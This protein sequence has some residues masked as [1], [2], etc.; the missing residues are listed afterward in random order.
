[1]ACGHLGHTRDDLF[2]EPASLAEMLSPVS[3]EARAVA[4]AFTRTADQ[5][6]GSS[7][8]AQPSLGAQI[9]ASL[10][11]SLLGV[12]G[13]LKLAHAMN[14][15]AVSQHESGSS[16]SDG[17]PS[18]TSSEDL[19][20][21]GGNSGGGDSDQGDSSGGGDSGGGDSDQ[22]DSSGGGDSGGGDSDQGDSSGGGDSGG[23]DSREVNTD[24]LADL[25]MT[26]PPVAEE[27]SESGVQQAEPGKSVKATF[28]ADRKGEVIRDFDG[29]PVS[30]PRGIDP[31]HLKV[32]IR[33]K[34][35]ESDTGTVFE[36]SVG[37]HVTD[38]RLQTLAR[39]P[40]EQILPKDT[41]GMWEIAEELQKKLGLPGT[42]TRKAR[43]SKLPPTRGDPHPRYPRIYRSLSEMM[44]T[45]DKKR[46]YESR[47]AE[48]EQKIKDFL[49]NLSDT[50]H[51]ERLEK[52][53]EM[54][55]NYRK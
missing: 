6:G 33:H 49:S 37:S 22:G 10:A 5:S 45:L 19:G 14:A 35:K 31:L 36:T 8:A 26:L 46:G 30:D 34:A 18:D 2:S 23:G 29:K 15:L 44:A 42:Q 51:E 27:P 48:G 24:I 40:V 32:D 16:D 53:K 38:R 1:M 17:A 43:Q 54:L 25:I 50:P 4:E 28:F 47:V 12:D 11:I 52:L 20:Y 7:S 39:K 55:R 13:A 41:P 3:A 9:G 21:W